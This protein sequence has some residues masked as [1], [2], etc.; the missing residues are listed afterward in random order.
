MPTEI[1]GGNSFSAGSG[2]IPGWTL[3]ANSAAPSSFSA[4]S[5]SLSAPFFTSE[6]NSPSASAASP[7]TSSIAAN[8]PPSTSPSSRVSSSAPPSLSSSGWS[9]TFATD[10]SVNAKLHADECFDPFLPRQP[11][12]QQF[13]LAFYINVKIKK[14]AAL[15]FRAHPL[16]QFGQRN[17][18]RAV[19][20]FVALFRFHDLLP[21][22][23]Q[24]LAQLLVP[25][26]LLWR[27]RLDVAIELAL[28]RCRLPLRLYDDRRVLRRQPHRRAA[29]NPKCQR[30]AGHALLTCIHKPFFPVLHGFPPNRICHV[31]SQNAKT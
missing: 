31:P 5:S 22:R 12:A 4:L 25:H 18:R 26:P 17:V 30:H 28:H 3:F 8:T 15:A 2:K 11:Q 27:Q 24:L 21:R 23:H 9:I 7:A 20:K 1:L 13:P 14:R 10:A 16:R 29:S 19:L 6:A